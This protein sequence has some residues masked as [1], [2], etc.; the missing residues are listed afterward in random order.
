MANMNLEEIAQVILTL[1]L[2]LFLGYIFVTYILF[3][4]RQVAPKVMTGA[5]DGRGY[6]SL[7]GGALVMLFLMAF[8]P[9]Y[10][11][12]AMLHGWGEFKPIIVEV[13]DDIVGDFTTI[14]TGGDVDYEIVVPEAQPVVPPVPIPVVPVEPTPTPFNY[15]TWTPDQ[16]VPTP[17]Y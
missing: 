14:T 3:L 2:Y 16:P 8:G 15:D 10:M 6:I 12:Q 13:S 11:G 17:E 4:M 5:M 7:F 9:Y 1:G